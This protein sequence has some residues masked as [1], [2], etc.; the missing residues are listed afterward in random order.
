MQLF[1]W[2]DFLVTHT[3]TH[4]HTLCVQTGHALTVVNCSLHVWL[5]WYIMVQW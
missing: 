2:I 1:L 3:H 5:E 4:M